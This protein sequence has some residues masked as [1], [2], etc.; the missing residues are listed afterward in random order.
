MVSV[1]RLRCVDTMIREE[2]K[3]SYGFRSA[4]WSQVS[5]LFAGSVSRRDGLEIKHRVV[6]NEEEWELEH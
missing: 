3:N 5:L 2:V 4:L 6:D 1:H